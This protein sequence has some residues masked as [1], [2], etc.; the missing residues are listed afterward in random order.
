MVLEVLANVRRHEKELRGIESGKEEIKLFLFT[1]DII[2]Y[3]E[4]PRNPQKS[5]RSNKGKLEHT[6]SVLKVN[7]TMYYQYAARKW[8][9]KKA[10]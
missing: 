3:I 5:P 8:N 9:G 2:V 1:D 6:Q 4:D 7:C 10:T